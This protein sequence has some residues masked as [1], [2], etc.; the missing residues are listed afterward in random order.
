MVN[1]KKSGDTPAEQ[2]AATHTVSHIAVERAAQRGI[3]A[4]KAAKEV[5]GILRAN[6]D[7]ITKLDPSILEA[8]SSHNDGVRWPALNDDVRTFVLDRS[9]RAELKAK[10]A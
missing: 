3:S 6:F 10:V 1:S 9:K 7:V 2:V 5:R 4:D 8:K